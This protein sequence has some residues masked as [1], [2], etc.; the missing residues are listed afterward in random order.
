M[1]HVLAISGM[2]ISYVVI[3]IQAVLNKLIN[4]KKLKN[5]I[6]ILILVFFAIIT[7]ASSSCV[8]ACIMSTMLLISQNFY[9][10]NNVI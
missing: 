6:V 7:G 9:R 4:N 2:H 3:G 10:K 1:S 8:R 5:Y